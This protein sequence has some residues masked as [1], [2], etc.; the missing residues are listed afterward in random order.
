MACRIAWFTMLES[1]HQIEYFKKMYKL[2]EKKFYHAWIGVDEEIFFY[3]PLVEKNKKY[4]VLFRGRLLPEAGGCVAVKAAKALEKYP[5]HFLMLA[6]GM[7]L[8]GI[9]KLI[10]ELNI[11]NITLIAEYLS[12]EKLRLEMQKCHLSLGQLSSHERLERTI[13]HKAYESL[14]LKLPY[15][16]ARNPGVMELLSEGETCLTFKPGNADDLANTILWAFHHNTTIQKIAENG[17]ELFMN[18]LICHKLGEKMLRHL[19][20][21][22]KKS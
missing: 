2:P 8:G 11:K 5:I 16:T 1:R 18:N 6:N 13:P 14:A 7:E 4:T 15:I 9:Q 19:D 17:Y 12:D 21:L 10:K 3:Q 20:S 22:E